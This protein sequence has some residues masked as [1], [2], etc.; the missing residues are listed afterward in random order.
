VFRTWGF[1]DKNATYD[2]N[3]MPQYGG[4]GAG[5]TE[6]IFQR[7]WPNGTSTVD[8][9]AFDKVV[10]AA[11]KVGI[12]L[13]V[14]FTNN[15]ADYGGMDVYTVNLGGRFHDDVSHFLYLLSPIT[16]KQ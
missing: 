7:W 8:I 9:S 13:I 15:W 2:P 4:E 16:Q 5:D 12:K 1:N 10:D 6:V 14:A 3:G 11:A